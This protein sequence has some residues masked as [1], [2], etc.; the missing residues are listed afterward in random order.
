M[1]ASGYFEEIRARRS[2]VTFI[3]ARLGSL[4]DMILPTPIDGKD[5]LAID[6]YGDLMGILATATKKPKSSILDDLGFW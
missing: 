4:I 5:Q 2:R 3:V 6:L 1:M